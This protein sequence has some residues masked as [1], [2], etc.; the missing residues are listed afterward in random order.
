MADLC[1]TTCGTIANVVS[2]YW[3]C[4][5]VFRKCGSNHFILIRCD[6]QF[7]DILDPAEWT[8]RIGENLI[9]ISPPGNFVPQAPTVSPFRVEGCGR[10]VTGVAEYLFD[11]TTYQTDEGLA[12]YEYWKN[13]M[14]NSSGY[15]MILVD[16]NEIFKLQD[17]WALAIDGGAP[18]S[19]SGTTPGFEF[20]ITVPAHEVEGEG[21]YCVWTTQFKI[22]KAGGFCARFLPGVLDVLA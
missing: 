1:S 19:V 14:E 9:H 3:D 6:L 7:T 10:E 20:S 17:D 2:S 11:F 5:D 22:K 8:T 18:A 12:D 16:C 4:T 15:R 21:E 13:L